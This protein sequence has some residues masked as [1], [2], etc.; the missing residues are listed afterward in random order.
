MRSGKTRYVGVSNLKGYQLQK[1]VELSRRYNYDSIIALQVG[2]NSSWNI[3]LFKRNGL[4][5]LNCHRMP[6]LGV[7]KDN[8]MICGIRSSVIRCQRVY[9]R[10]DASQAHSI[11]SSLKETYLR[12]R[13]FD[14]IHVLIRGCVA[15][16]VVPSDL[17]YG[18]INFCGTLYARCLNK[19]WAHG[20]TE[21]N[22]CYF[23]YGLFY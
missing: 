22:V 19:I 17:Y 11:I 18:I 20:S 5:G 2:V 10:K 13:I 21:V 23:W 4:G 7:N 1:Y 16:R 14:L 6:S 15:L 3:I 12:H 8:V 9:F